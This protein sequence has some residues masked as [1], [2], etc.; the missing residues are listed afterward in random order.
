M[1]TIVAK[2]VST[3]MVKTIVV[4]RILTRQHPLYKKMMRSSHRLKVHTD[5]E[6]SV[7]DTVKIASTRPI[8]RDVHYKVIEKVTK[9]V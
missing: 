6:V 7:G 1:K 4:E 8:S 9:T 3:K 5:I 2:V